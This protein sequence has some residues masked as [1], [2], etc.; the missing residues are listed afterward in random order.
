MPPKKQSQLSKPTTS[1]SQG[2]PV[3]IQKPQQSKPTI[4]SSQGQWV[5]IPENL[6]ANGDL[7]S[8]RVPCNAWRVYCWLVNR[9][10]KNIKIEGEDTIYGVVAGENLVPCKSIAKGLK[11]SWSSVRRSLNWL[12]EKN[13][14]TRSR[15]GKGEE[16][17]YYVVN[18]IRALELER[19]DAEWLKLSKEENA[20]EELEFLDE[21]KVQSFNIE[22]DD[23]LA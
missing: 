6:F 13:L 2:Q 17:R 20:G 7:W 1:D 18:S 11:T 19:R 5:P 10:T 23:E 12:A 8:G 9:C 3:S 16:Y 22:G 14:I 4:S 21:S 15:S